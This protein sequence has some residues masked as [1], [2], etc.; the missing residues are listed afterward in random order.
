MPETKNKNLSKQGREPTTA[1]P[2]AI[3][4]LTE[5]LLTSNVCLILSAS[6]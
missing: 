6:I 3:D 5:L 4:C 2:F 1:F